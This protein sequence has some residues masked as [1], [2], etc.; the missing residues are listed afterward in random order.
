MVLSLIYVY[1]IVLVH[2][3]IEKKITM[4]TQPLFSGAATGD[5]PVEVATRGGRGSE[6]A[7]AP[8]AAGGGSRCWAG[9]EGGGTRRG[10][11]AAVE[12]NKIV[13]ER[14]KKV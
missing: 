2:I 8:P 11:G 13:R 10:E 4:N 9:C 7:L 1:L 3:V 5:R 14:G 12:A 6:A